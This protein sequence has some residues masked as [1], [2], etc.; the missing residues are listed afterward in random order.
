M[1]R[2]DV[3]APPPPPAPLA[4]PASPPE[5]VTPEGLSH[6]LA[7]VASEQPA[8]AVTVTDRAVALRYATPAQYAA[9]TSPDAE[10][11]CLL[12]GLSPARACVDH[13]R[14]GVAVVTFAR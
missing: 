9:R 4:E 14:D 12:F 2:K 1:A 5:A 6:A 10:A 11:L 7:A 8:P 3:P 13:A